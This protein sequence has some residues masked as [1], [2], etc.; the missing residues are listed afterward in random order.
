MKNR[1]ILAIIGIGIIGTI[2]AVI[3]ALGALSLTE[4]FIAIAGA[5]IVVA[6]AIAWWG[7]RE[8]IEGKEEP[9]KVEVIN[10]PSVVAPVLT[11]SPLPH[12]KGYMLPPKI[13]IKDI[14]NGLKQA[15]GKAPEDSNQ[16]ARFLQTSQ[17]LEVYSG[18]V[19][20]PLKELIVKF[21]VIRVHCI[22]GEAINCKVQARA[23]SIEHFGK[24]QVTDWYDV[25]YVNWFSLSKKRGLQ[26]SFFEGE[27][28]PKG[29]GINQYLT[30]VIENLHCDDEKDL[31][32]F[33][34]IKD[35]PTVFLCT[36]GASAMGHTPQRFLRKN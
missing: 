3:I 25:G 9:Q 16:E 27:D 7:F 36:D 1:Q 31:L 34:M 10:L 18:K 26:K 12:Y 23:R 33:Y 32:L 5:L 30:N 17:K 19:D 24:Q 20:E 11:L 35:I 14:G 21:G 28:K 13:E 2:L 8:K 4:F 6:I 22:S 15:T 29:F